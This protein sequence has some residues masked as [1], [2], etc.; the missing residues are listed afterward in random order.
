MPSSNEDKINLQTQSD[1]IVFRGT[2]NM[3]DTIKRYDES[4]TQMNSYIENACKDELDAMQKAQI[5]LEKKLQ[6]IIK[7]KKVRQMED[8]LQSQSD[9]VSKQM[10][11][12]QRELMK[13]ENEIEDDITLSEKDR[14]KKMHNL[15]K[16]A[17][18]QYKRF[19]EKYPAAIKAQIISNLRHLE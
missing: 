17:V 2:Q 1:M 15:H 13:M 7:D 11:K 16:A 5:A 8:M 9:D 12:M 18:S 14:Q 6:N 4:I 3:E 10:R 19:S